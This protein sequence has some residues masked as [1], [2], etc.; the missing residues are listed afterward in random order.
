MSEVPNSIP[1]NINFGNET[2]D[3]FVKPQSYLQSKVSAVTPTGIPGGQAVTT[4]QLVELMNI[5]GNL[6]IVDVWNNSSHNKIPGSVHLGF[7]G[8]GG[9]FNDE[10]QVRL[11]ASLAELTDGQRDR[12]LVFYCMGTP[13]WESY[14]AAL[15]AIVMGYSRVYWYRGGVQAWVEAKLPVAN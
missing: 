15:R 6:V 2:T 5:F 11:K 13:C 7:A 14:N 12:P 8:Q 3:Y 4:P 10:V 1:S 9:S